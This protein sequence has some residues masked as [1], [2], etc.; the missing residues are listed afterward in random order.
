MKHV[1]IILLGVFLFLSGCN[2]KIPFEQ[3]SLDEVPEDIRTSIEE[4]PSASTGMA[5]RGNKAY[6]IIIGEVGQEIE[7]IT[8][9]KFDV[10]Y[11][12]T[13]SSNPNSERPIKVVKFRNNG[14][15]VGFKEVK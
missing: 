14:S 9:E 2:N 7:V 5:E 3:I 6:A 1:F 10:H 15:P 8:V 4:T 12:I 11:R 13:E